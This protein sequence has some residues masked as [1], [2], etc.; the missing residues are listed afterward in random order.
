MENTTNNGPIL[1]T[2]AA[3]QLGAV[4]RTVTSLLF[5]RGLPVH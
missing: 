4:E 2:G 5:K 3:G 1:A